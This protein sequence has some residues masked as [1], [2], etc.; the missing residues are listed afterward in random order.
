MRF[1]YWDGKAAGVG[2]LGEIWGAWFGL[3]N[4]RMYSL[5]QVY[6]QIDGCICGQEFRREARLV[7]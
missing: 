1:Y 3:T 7:T 2:G 5:I 6:G 4:F